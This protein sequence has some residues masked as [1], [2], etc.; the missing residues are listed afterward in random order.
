MQEK[1]EETASVAPPPTPKPKKG[2]KIPKLHLNMPHMTGRRASKTS[3]ISSINEEAILNAPGGKLTGPLADVV[4]QAM[5]GNSAK[6]STPKTKRKSAMVSSIVS[7]ITN[8][9]V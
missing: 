6:P 4:L 1:E 9:T 3:D 8:S 7:Y 5:A 2:R